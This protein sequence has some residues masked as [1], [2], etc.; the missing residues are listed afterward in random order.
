MRSEGLFKASTSVTRPLEGLETGNLTAKAGNGAEVL[1]RCQT[2]RRWPDREMAGE[3][4]VSR[5][6]FGESHV[7]G[8]STQHQADPNEVLCATNWRGIPVDRNS[9]LHDR[10]LAWGM[11]TREPHD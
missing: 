9:N 8:A 3:D 10:D 5:S 4:G 2:L 7:H 6:S 1:S 11:V